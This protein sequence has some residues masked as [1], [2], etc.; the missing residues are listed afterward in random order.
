M[1]KLSKA[2]CVIKLVSTKA[3]CKVTICVILTV[4]FESPSLMTDL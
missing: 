4:V 1:L 2:L 3:T